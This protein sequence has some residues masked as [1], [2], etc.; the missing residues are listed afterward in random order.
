MN[1]LNFI[2]LFAGAG[3]LS[4]G[5]VRQGYSPVVH[6]E[7]NNYA[8]E[9][10]KTRVSYHWLKDKGKLDFYYRYLQGEVS[11]S[12][13]WAA[14]P[15]NLISSVINIEISAQNIYN[16]FN[17]IDNQ[18]K[19]KKIDLI[20]GSP[21]C[22]TYSIM[23]RARDPNNMKNDQRNYLYKFYVK[24]LEKYN[25]QMFVFENVPGLLSAGNGKYF[26]DI[27]TS[28]RK[29]GYDTNYKVLNAKD[30]GVLQN[31]KRIILIGWLKNSGLKY[32]DFEIQENKWQILKDLFYDLP[33]LK[34]STGETITFYRLPV[35]EYLKKSHIRND[36]EFT[37][38]HE[39]RPQNE[40]D[41]EI[42]KIAI[43]KWL[44][45]KKKL[46]YAELPENLQTHKN[47][48]TFLNRFQVINPFGVSHTLIAHISSEGCYYIYPDLNQV[49]SISVREAA[50]I[51]SFPDDYF[52]EGGRTSAFRQIGNA[53]P[54]LMAEGIAKKIKELF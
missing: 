26:E 22:Q 11:K 21:P 18:I 33:S 34:P 16:I 5:F 53:V 15:E 32:P 37:T 49:R 42:Y 7:M 6:I 35:N 40:R 39:A 10:L 27:I 50:R 31:R 28:V 8:C 13:L 36:I 12:D 20:I 44:N 23:S 14:I 41:L 54:P 9:T 46:N 38:Q 4:E 2:D 29:I 19:N 3:G 48:T 17:N 51:Q 30:F 1:K 43:I 25:P 47:K 45:E 24:F 52:F